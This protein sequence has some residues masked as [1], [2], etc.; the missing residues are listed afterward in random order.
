MKNK[1]CASVV[2][3][4]VGL[5]LINA[6][7]ENPWVWVLI[8]AL[9]GLVVWVFNWQ[10]KR[11]SASDKA[12]HLRNLQILEQLASDLPSND[13][14]GLS[15]KQGEVV[16]HRLAS[17]GLVEFRSNGSSYSGGS[18]GVSIRVMKGLSYRV[19]AN[20]GTITK[21]PE[22]LQ[23]IDEG[24]ATFTNKRVVFAGANQ[25]REWDFEKFLGANVTANGITAYM[26]V[27]N[28]QKTSGLTWTDHSDL[29]PGFALAVANDYFEGGL[30]AAKRRCLET[31]GEIR[32]LLSLEPGVGNPVASRIKPESNSKESSNNYDL[33]TG[34]RFEIVGES[35]NRD[36]FER[37]R[38]ARGIDVGSTA[39]VAATLVA[40]PE[41]I[42]SANGKAV[43]VKLEGMTLGHIAESNNEAFFD[44]LLANGGTATCQAEIFFDGEA[45]PEGPRNS[46]R[47]FVKMPPQLGN[48]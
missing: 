22:T 41:N 45:S 19:G 8:V 33:K 4:A 13:S 24:S 3:V 6:A 9:I 44:L 30:E 10:S 7:T 17:V 42:H 31:A 2:V 36:S 26:P 14:G 21:N 1:G 48:K 20:R 23:L 40:E 15:L 37:I 12:G 43:A 34:P 32:N 5:T 28:R 35:F 18:Q 11:K 39:S 16:V 25:S 38:Q 47:L 27:S 29:P 46:V